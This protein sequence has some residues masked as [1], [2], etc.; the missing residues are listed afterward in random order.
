MT[1]TQT[2]GAEICNWQG[3]DYV[4]INVC[5]R[6]F[7][8]E[9]SVY[10]IRADDAQGVAQLQA[11]VDRSAERKV[12]ESYLARWMSRQELAQHINGQRDHTGS[13]YLLTL[14]SNG[15]QDAMRL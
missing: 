1:R 7:A 13:I 8:N 4:A 6:G 14:D 9:F 5:P 12:G 3:V 2:T 15:N 11:R 10:V